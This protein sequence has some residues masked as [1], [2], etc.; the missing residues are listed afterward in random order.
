[1][2]FTF[3]S[4]FA[5]RLEQNKIT[6]GDTK[7]NQKNF[8][9]FLSTRTQQKQCRLRSSTVFDNHMWLGKK[10]WN[11]VECSLIPL[12]L[13]MVPAREVHPFSAAAD[14]S[15]SASPSLVFASLK[16]QVYTQRQTTMSTNW[17]SLKEPRRSICKAK[18]EQDPIS[19]V[20]SSNCSFIKRCSLLLI[21][22]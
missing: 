19:E 18:D 12:F 21:L 20:C 15:W 6:E 7:Y 3:H 14:V 22:A 9:R 11:D 16:L 5:Y 13:M 4:D 1:M 17:T 2:I 10:N 8:L